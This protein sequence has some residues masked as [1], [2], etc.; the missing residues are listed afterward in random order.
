MSRPDLPFASACAELLGR[1][2]F[3]C[4]FLGVMLVA[5]GLA[6]TLSGQIDPDI[7]AARG[8]GVGA[9]RDGDLSRFVSA[10]FLSHSLPMLLRQLVFAALVIGRVEWLWGTWRAA[11]LFFAV[12]IAASLL[13][14]AAVALVPGLGALAAATDVG[15]SMGGFGAIGFLIVRLRHRG[16]ALIAILGL[17]AVKYALAPAP[18]ADGGHVI[19]L[20]LGF[21]LGLG[22]SR[23][24]GLAKAPKLALQ[25]PAREQAARRPC[26]QD[27]QL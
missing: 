17:I 14:L 16:A 22:G 26:Q 10:I 9:L 23:M 6:G 27:G 1:V 13:L 25:K 2:P 20:G 12:D 19:A 18:L 4:A 21:C 24:P 8:I 5:N 11:G 7:L 3:T 15:M